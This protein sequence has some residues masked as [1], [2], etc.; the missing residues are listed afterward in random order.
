M[1]KTYLAP[2]TF[3]QSVYLI[4]GIAADPTINLGSGRGASG[5]IDQPSGEYYEGGAKERYDVDK[6][7]Y[8]NLW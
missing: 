1:K 7:E 6:V 3:D 4:N 2:M 5:K 8:G